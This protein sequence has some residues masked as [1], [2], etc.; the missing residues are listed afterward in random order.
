MSRG[1]VPRRGDRRGR[2]SSGVT[3]RPRA[4]TVYSTGKGS[5][6]ARCGWPEHDCRCAAR[7][8][9]PVPEK[10]AV[11]LRIEKAGRGGK[12]VTVVG[13]LPRN[14]A[15]LKT[16]V[17]ELKRACGTGGTAAADHVELQGDHR[18]AL[19]TMLARKGWT[20]KG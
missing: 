6:C 11:A 15:F 19:R 17:G 16:L 9:E 14:A 1:G 10:L 13:G 5:R 12:T 7:L 20:V 4:R 3:E 18:A 8:D 2:Y